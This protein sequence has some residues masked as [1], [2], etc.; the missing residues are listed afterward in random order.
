MEKI[1]LQLLAMSQKSSKSSHCGFKND[2]VKSIYQTIDGFSVELIMVGIDVVTGED[3]QDG[4]NL[5]TIVTKYW[6][7]VEGLFIHYLP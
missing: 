3:M 7:T 1:I 5:A 6:Q 2:R 4:R